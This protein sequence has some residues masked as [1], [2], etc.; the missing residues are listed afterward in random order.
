MAEAAHVV[1][2]VKLVVNVQMDTKANECM[3]F[4]VAKVIWGK[5]LWVSICPSA[6]QNCSSMESYVA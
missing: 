4:D 3:A 2:G 5:N 6:R 1:L